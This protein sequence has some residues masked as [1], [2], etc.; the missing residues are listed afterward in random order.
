MLATVVNVGA[1]ASAIVAPEP[2]KPAA[3][4]WKVDV[5]T[6]VGCMCLYYPVLHTYTVDTTL[7]SLL[8]VELAQ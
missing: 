2:K 1:Q 5:A 8:I 4:A 6:L 3:Q 7:C